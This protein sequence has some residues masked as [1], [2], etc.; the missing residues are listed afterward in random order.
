[1]VGLAESMD[2]NPH[3]FYDLIVKSKNDINSIAQKPV[4][5]ISLEDNI[6]RQIRNHNKIMDRA[7]A[8]SVNVHS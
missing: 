4:T 6:L 1:M 7:I 2:S 8:G 3:P 5:S